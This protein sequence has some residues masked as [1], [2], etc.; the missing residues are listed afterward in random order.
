M[1]SQYEKHFEG[2]DYVSEPP[3]ATDFEACTFRSCNFSKLHLDAFKFRE[4]VFEECDLSNV[5]LSESILQDTEFRNCKLIG[6]NFSD[7]N[8]F[9]FSTSFVDCQLDMASFAE[10]KLNKVSITRSRLRGTDLYGAEMTGCTLEEC[11]L[12]ETL[13]EQTNLEKVDLR[14][15]KNYVIDPEN[16]RIKGAKFSYPQVLGLLDKYNIKVDLS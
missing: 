13:F 10:M 11:D 4:C 2:R 8:Q 14:S 12:K 7:I 16:N 3:T 5:T 9:G 15:C 1:E 6:V